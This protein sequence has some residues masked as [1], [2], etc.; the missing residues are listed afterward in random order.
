M[1]RGI[2]AALDRSLTTG[3]GVLNGLVQTDAA[4]SSGNSGGPLVDAAGRVV[5]ITTAI[6]YGY[7]DT[8]ANSVGFAISVAEL[9]PELAALRDAALGAV[10]PDGYL[11]VGLAPRRDGGLGAT[12]VQIEAGS[13]ADLGG[14]LVDDVVV[15]LDG[16]AVLGDADLMAA[17]RDRRPGELV[18]VDIVRD[19]GR[20][21]RTVVLGARAD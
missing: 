6:A 17:V 21:Q 7:A 20:A 10:V 12:I 19:G 9:L 1:T 5:G 2:V 16:A 13:P 4:I 15:G 3:N 11:G 18:V 8:A 14:L